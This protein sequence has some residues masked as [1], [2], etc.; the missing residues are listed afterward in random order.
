MQEYCIYIKVQGTSKSIDASPIMSAFTA[1]PFWIGNDSQGIY[2]IMKQLFSELEHRYIGY[3]NQVRLLLSQLL[4]SL[5]RNYK[6]CPVS[7]TT[8]TAN[9]LSD[10][11]SI[12]IEE[13]FL[14]EYQSL[15]LEELAGRLKLSP[16]Q[17]QRLLLKYYG[18]SFQQKKTESRM[19]AAAILLSDSGR[20]ISS[21]AEALGYSSSEHFSSS[22]QKYYHTSPR[23]FRKLL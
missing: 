10:S 20:S 17:T 2:S 16:R 6:K 14:Y 23:E 13:Y 4:I 19:S 8:F 21:I 11:N 12:I 7:S 1:V 15:S 22:F 3:Q 18:K 5:V 9:N